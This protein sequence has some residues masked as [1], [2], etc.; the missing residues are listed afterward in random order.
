MPSVDGDTRQDERDIVEKRLRALVR[1][2][3]NEFRHYGSDQKSGL[4][5]DDLPES[6]SYV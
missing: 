3:I 5:G 2:R 1:R 4:S 6:L